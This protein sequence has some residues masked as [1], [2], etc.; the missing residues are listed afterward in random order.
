MEREIEAA[1]CIPVPFGAACEQLRTDAGAVL[2][3]SVVAPV[4]AGTAV[5]QTVRVEVGELQVEPTA[6]GLPVSWS[7]EAHEKLLPSFDGR[8][9]LVAESLSSTRLS[10]YGTYT[11]P[12]GPVGRFGDSLVGRRIARASVTDLVERVARALEAGYRSGAGPDRP[13][14]TTGGVDLR[15]HD[16]VGTFATPSE[17]FIG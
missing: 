14:A 5:E 10:L 1:T 9:V 11:V 13:A 4:G 16:P 2:P 8:L 6:A 17:H 15:E 12:L 7:P 3:T